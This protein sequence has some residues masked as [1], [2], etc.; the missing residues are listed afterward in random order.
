[1]A[2]DRIWFVDLS[3][4]VFLYAISLVEKSDD[5]D[6]FGVFRFLPNKNHLLFRF[7][8]PALVSHVGPRFSISCNLLIWIFFPGKTTNLRFPSNKCSFFSHVRIFQILCKADERRINNYY[9]GATGLK[10]TFDVSVSV[11][12]QN[13]QHKFEFWI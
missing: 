12:M 2:F 10:R 7:L 5:F 6:F 13:S 9:E 4:L 11:I 3:L 8:F 1:M